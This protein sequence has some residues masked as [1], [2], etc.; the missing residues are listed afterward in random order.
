MERP[1]ERTC[2]RY[3]HTYT[4]HTYI[5]AHVQTHMHVHQIILHLTRYVITYEA[6]QKNTHVHTTAKHHLWISRS[7]EPSHPCVQRHSHRLAC[8]ESAVMAGSGDRAIIFTGAL[9]LVACLFLLLP[10]LFKSAPIR[11]WQHLFFTGKISAKHSR[12]AFSLYFWL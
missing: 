10:M 11:L 7:Q 5:H 8:Q 6:C 12:N 3:S 1:W 2:S 9:P 4:T